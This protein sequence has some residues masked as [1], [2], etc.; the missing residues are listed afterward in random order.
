MVARTASALIGTGRDKPVPYGPH[1]TP[2]CLVGATLVVARGQFSRLPG[3]RDGTTPADASLAQCPAPAP[4][5]PVP[6]GS[7]V[8]A[9]PSCTRRLTNGATTMTVTPIPTPH[10]PKVAKV[11]V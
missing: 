6:Y 11:S 1:P 10:H 2:V 3:A 7:G 9:L 4:T 5:G 8:A